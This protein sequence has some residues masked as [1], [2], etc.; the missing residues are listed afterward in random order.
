MKVVRC[1]ECRSILEENEFFD[2][3]DIVYCSVCDIEFE[4][5]DAESLIL[6]KFT[7]FEDYDKDVD[8]IDEDEHEH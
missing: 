1:P 3:G 4:I 7:I 8:Q 2:E 5:V 6:K